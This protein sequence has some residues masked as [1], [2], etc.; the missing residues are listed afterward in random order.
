MK[1]IFRSTRQNLT[2][3]VNMNTSHYHYY[4]LA[5]SAQLSQR[6]FATIK[7]TTTNGH[8]LHLLALI[9][10]LVLVTFVFELLVLFEDFGWWWLVVFSASIRSVLILIRGLLRP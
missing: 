7:G 1:R 9:V 8:Q 6:V 10:W 5:V 3:N 2:R 4:Q